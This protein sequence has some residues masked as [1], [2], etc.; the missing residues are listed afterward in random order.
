MNRPSE[1]R[2]LFRKGSLA[3]AYRRRKALGYTVGGRLQSRLQQHTMLS[4]PRAKPLP[5]APMGKHLTGCCKAV[6][7]AVTTKYLVSSQFR[8]SANE[9]HACF[10]REKV[11]ST[12]YLR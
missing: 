10:P 11:F 6:G 8:S 5:S 2:L 9:L 3:R 4:A 1:E 12:L 7:A